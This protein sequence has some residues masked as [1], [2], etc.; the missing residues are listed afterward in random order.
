MPR[1]RRKA[2]GPVKNQ[3][4]EEPKWAWPV[5]DPW[6]LAL[7]GCW[8]GWSRMGL[9][10]LSGSKNDVLVPTKVDVIAR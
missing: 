6:A 5:D 10:S 3:C 8:T 1:G 4:R 7:L 2:T 9:G